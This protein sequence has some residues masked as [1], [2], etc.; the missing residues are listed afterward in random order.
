M[1]VCGSSVNTPWAVILFREGA[2]ELDGGSGNAPDGGEKVGGFARVV[3][4]F[5]PA[6]L[7]TPSAIALEPGDGLGV[8]SCAADADGRMRR[9]GATDPL[10]G[11]FAISSP[12]ADGPAEDGLDVCDLISVDALPLRFLRRYFSMAS[13]SCCSVLFAMGVRADAGLCVSGGCKTEP[14]RKCEGDEKVPEEFW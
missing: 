4:G 13:A 1:N 3:D 12:F 8:R 9:R 11:R 14:L 2:R 5:V 10:N 6:R 7:R